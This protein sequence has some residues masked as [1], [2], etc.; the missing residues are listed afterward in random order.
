MD[1]RIEQILKQYPFISEDIQ[2]AQAELNNYIALQ[3]EARDTLKGQALTG[4]PHNPGVSDQTYDAVERLIDLYQAQIDE[5]VRRVNELL[6]LKKWLDKAFTTLTE[7]ERRVLYLRYDER[8]QV[9]KIMQRMGIQKDATF[10]RIINSAKD[11]VKNVM[12]K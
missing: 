1:Y 7:D 10:Y 5:Y 12:Y 9:W 8:W 4:M 11:K 6:D 3:Y 2:K